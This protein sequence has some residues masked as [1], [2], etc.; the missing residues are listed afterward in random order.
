MIDFIREAK[1]SFSFNS[2]AKEIS[3][4]CQ[5]FLNSWN[6]ENFYYVRIT[7]KARLI[8]LTNRVDFAM[9]YWEAGLP[10]RTGFDDSLTE[11]QNYTVLWESVLEKEILKFAEAKHCF[12]GFSFVDRYYDTIQF[13]SFLR[14]SPREN[15][16]EFYLKNEHVLRCW[17]REFEWKNRSLIKYAEQNAIALPK[18]YLATE[19]EAF[20]PKRTVN[21]RYRNIQS[22]I[23]FR[24]L[25]CL[26]LYSRGFTH[27]HIAN[28]LGIS[29]RT[30]ETHI[31]DVKNRFGL[32]SRDEL[33]S[34]AYADALVQAYSPRLR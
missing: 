11:A 1:T 28:L 24:Q 16:Y 14:S 18:A 17:L 13:I 5:P 9:D 29:Q 27:C 32:S 6:F 10:L 22:K 23:S 30:I 20:Y 7:R 26:F 34:L 2:G 3:R 4:I 25:D 33:A 19:K 8:Y 21:L 31:E 12:N 15:A